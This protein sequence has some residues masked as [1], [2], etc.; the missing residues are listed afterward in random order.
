MK[1]KEKLHNQVVF[2]PYNNKQM[3]LLPPSLEEL[4]AENHPVRVVNSV[5]DSLDI[6]LLESNYESGGTSSYHP[7]MLLKVVVYSYLQNIYSSRGMENGLKEHIHMMWLSGMSYPDHNT[8]NR[9]R[10]HRLKDSLKE[11]FR[12]VVLLLV[13]SGHISLKSIYTAS[14][15][16]AQK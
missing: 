3:L 11:I 10:S 2:K 6:S 5:I 8:L 16:M 12:Q 15:R 9:F 14:T 7:R 4:I 1:S 13:E